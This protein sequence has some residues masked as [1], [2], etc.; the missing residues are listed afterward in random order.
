[1]AVRDSPST[2]RPRPHAVNQDHA[3]SVLAM[4]LALD[5]TAK[6]AR[7]SA[8]TKTRVT[9]DVVDGKDPKRRALVWP[10]DPPLADAGAAIIR[11][12]YEL[13]GVFMKK[14]R[15]VAQAAG[16]P[17]VMLVH[18]TGHSLRSGG[19]TD[20][21][22]S[23]MSQAEVQRQGGW[24]SDAILIYDRPQ[25]HHRASQARRMGASMRRMLAARR[26]H[27]AAQCGRHAQ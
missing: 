2:R 24:S 7:M 3:A 16:M 19:T 18:L 22:A 21:M 10:L 25:S 13:P 12:S 8:I 6:R 20:W 27:G 26:H 14:M 4:A 9:L 17:A 5:P 23:G 1:M 15:R 11:G